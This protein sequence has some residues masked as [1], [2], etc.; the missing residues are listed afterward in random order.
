MSEE[1]SC[2]KLMLRGIQQLR[3]QNFAIFHHPA[4]RG[5]FLYP[6]RGQKQTFFEPLPPYLV[7]VVIEWPLNDFFLSFDSIQPITTS[8]IL[9]YVD[10]KT[11]F[12]LL[13]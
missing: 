10:K 12:G 13:N 1:G 6:E 8:I 9:F 5:Q 7:H 4:L 3:G 2:Q 11:K